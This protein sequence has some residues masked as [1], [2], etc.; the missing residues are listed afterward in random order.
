MKNSFLFSN[1]GISQDFLEKFNDLNI[2]KKYDESEAF[3][4]S[5]DVFGSLNQIKFSERNLDKKQLSNLAIEVVYQLFKQNQ[6]NLFFDLSKID[7]E[8]E[9]VEKEDITQELVLGLGDESV[10]DYKSKIENKKLLNEIDKRNIINTITQGYA[11]KIRKD[12]ILDASIKTEGIDITAN[13]NLLT[14][15]EKVKRIAISENSPTDIKTI[16]QQVKEYMPYDGGKVRIEF[17]ENTN[18][19]KIIAKASI[20]ILL[21]HE[22]VNGIYEII[23][24]HGQKKVET[25]I[26]Q[27]AFEVTDTF[28]EEFYAFV[29]SEYFLERIE[30]LFEKIENILIQKNII[31]RKN[32]QIYPFLLAEFYSHP[33]PI[34]LKISSLIFQNDDNKLPIS[35]FEELYLKI[36]LNNNVIDIQIYEDEI[37]D[38]NKIIDKVIILGYEFLSI[39]EKIFLARL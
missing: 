15:D 37:F 8:A 26:L 7:I 11:H 14:K 33:A 12:I 16:F 18:R 20:F 9:I 34:F 27:K 5:M 32:I 29:Y 39:K 25:E 13:M 19:Y 36:L 31:K 35:F 22:I 6:E 30:F 10:T 17:N 38:V 24:L 4:L 1:S 2:P 21:V 3:L 28:T 23:G